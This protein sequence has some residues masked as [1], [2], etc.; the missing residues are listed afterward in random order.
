MLATPPVSRNPSEE[1]I[2]RYLPLVERVVTSVRR[3]I[4]PHIPRTDLVCAGVRGLVDALRR[5]DSGHGPTF[6]RYAWIR[7]RGAVFDE[8]REQ[9]W[10]SRTARDA[11]QPTAI[12][13]LG[14]MT[15]NE[16]AAH[17]ADEGASALQLFE[18]REERE[19]I[20]RAIASLPA[21]EQLIV[22]MRYFEGAQLDEIAG[23]LSVSRARVSQ[24]H[25]RAVE[26]LRET[27]GAEL[28]A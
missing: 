13:H 12:V 21:R 4:P 19:T 20:A 3:R 18:R 10:M 7:I 15:P 5:D 1:E 17:T 23:K 25:G 14:D 24:L 16:E 11:E 27:L 2:R 28:F 6:E 26:M 9:D 8:L 22:K